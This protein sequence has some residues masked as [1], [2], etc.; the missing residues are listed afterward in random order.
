MTAE[1][2]DSRHVILSWRRPGFRPRLSRIS[3]TRPLAPPV[4]SREP[5]SPSTAPVTPLLRNQSVVLNTIRR[6]QTPIAVASAQP[7]TIPK[8]TRL[9]FPAPQH[10]TSTCWPSHR[11]PSACLTPRHPSPLGGAPGARYARL[12]STKSTAAHHP[13]VIQLARHIQAINTTADSLVAPHDGDAHLPRALFHACRYLYI[14]SHATFRPPWLLCSSRRNLAP[15]R[16]ART[17]P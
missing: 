10:R 16:L 15:R 8:A 4:R 5:F 9:V 2:R 14:I 1:R 6:R 11:P 7:S 3:L 13:G 17:P 12:P